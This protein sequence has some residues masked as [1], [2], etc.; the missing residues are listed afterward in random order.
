MQ[1]LAPSLCQSNTA[2]GNGM[3]WHQYE[4][5]HSF[6]QYSWM[7]KMPIL[8]MN[9]HTFWEVTYHVGGLNAAKRVAASLMWTEL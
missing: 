8:S 4:I 9:V 2:S 7:A 5:L 1:S 3:P 6:Q